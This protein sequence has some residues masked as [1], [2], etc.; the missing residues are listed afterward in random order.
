[1]GKRGVIARFVAVALLWLAATSAIAHALGGVVGDVVEGSAVLALLVV[2]WSAF[3]PNARLF[4]R[5]IG[6]G[7]TPTPKF[8]LTFD[9]GPSP[10]HTPAV[11]D[12]LRAA[13]ARGTLF[14][15]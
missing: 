7:V 15:R 5:V 14:L 8:A 3:T 6:T 12:A 9:D 10:Q 11:L 1:M 2:A 4:G 13:G